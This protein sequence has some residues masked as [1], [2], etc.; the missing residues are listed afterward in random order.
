MKRLFKA[1]TFILILGL[2]APA[3]KAGA[4]ESGYD[5]LLQRAEQLLS[6]YKDSEA[7]TV[8]E[9][10]LAAAPDNY[11][12]LCK[13]SFLHSRI[14]DRYNDDSRKMEH[15]SKAKAYASHAYEINPTDDESNYVMA[16]SLSCIAMI[17]G[18]KQRL[19][20]T[21]QIKSF[22]DAAL[23]DNQEN[24][25]AWHLLGRW[26]YKMANLNFAEIAAS[27]MLFGGV[28]EKAS[29]EDAVKALQMAIKYNPQ[30]IRYYYDLA[31]VLQDMNDHKACISTLEQA[32][33]LHLE[34]RE[35]LELSRRC[36]I[37]L[38]EQVR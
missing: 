7:L 2:S 6:N 24:A 8:Y 35:E 10:V 22:L 36:K 4:A 31:N 5:K 30:N 17:S 12:A 9:E 16:L 32:L 18:P 29:N 27:K 34:T 1:I 19:S 37:M 25:A 21:N 23:A 33:T 26:Y 14:G 15:F 13:A 3:V 38:Q 20:V 28:C 11:E